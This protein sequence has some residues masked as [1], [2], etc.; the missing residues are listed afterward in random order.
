MIER[1]WL[2]LENKFNNIKLYEYIVMPNHFHWV[3]EIC[4]NVVAIPCGCPYRKIYYEML[5]DDLNH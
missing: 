1:C 4:Q 5:F 3:I 2:E